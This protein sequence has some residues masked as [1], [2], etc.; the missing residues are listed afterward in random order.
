MPSVASLMEYY[1][2]NPER[3][4]PLRDFLFREWAS[5]SDDDP[6]GVLAGEAFDLIELHRRGA[7]GRA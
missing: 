5:R 3:R 7:E 4:A 6:W 2:A 1:F